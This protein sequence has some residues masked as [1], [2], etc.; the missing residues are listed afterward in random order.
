MNFAREEKPTQG[1]SAEAQGAQPSA[2]GTRQSRAAERGVDSCRAGAPP[3]PR[4]VSGR[5]AS[6]TRAGRRAGRG[7]GA[8]R[9]RGGAGACSGAEPGLTLSDAGIHLWLPGAVTS[10]ARAVAAPGPQASNRPGLERAL[11]P[12]ERGELK[13]AP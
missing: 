8:A 9:S 5:G 10:A 3:G 6:L 4:P 2:G 12:L 13:T 1:I 11:E 7:R